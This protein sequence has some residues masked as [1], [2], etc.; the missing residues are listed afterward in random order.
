MEVRKGAGIRKGLC[1]ILQDFSNF[2]TI[3]HGE[4][5]FYIIASYTHIHW[6]KKYYK[7]TLIFH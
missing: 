6:I 3:T 1:G 7:I 2:F 5:I 4:Y